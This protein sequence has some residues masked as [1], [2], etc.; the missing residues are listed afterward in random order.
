MILALLSSS[1]NTRTTYSLSSTNV[2]AELSLPIEDWRKRQRRM[3]RLQI[4]WVFFIGTTSS[5]LVL[6]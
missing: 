5:S 6:C 3:Q 2:I 4:W 1:K